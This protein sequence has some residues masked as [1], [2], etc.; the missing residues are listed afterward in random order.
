MLPC[1]LLLLC[2]V[3]VWQCQLIAH[4]IIHNAALPSVTACALQHCKRGKRLP[5]TGA[6][7]V[8]VCVGCC[9]WLLARERQAPVTG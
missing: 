3:C 6:W 7:E 2:V 1:S 9:C 4:D 5:A 8:W